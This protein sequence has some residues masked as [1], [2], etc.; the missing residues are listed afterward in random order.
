MVNFPILVFY[1]FDTAEVATP[2]PNRHIEG[3]SFAFRQRVALGC[4]EYTGVG[5]SGTLIFED[6]E[7]NT[8]LDQSHVES[9]VTA[10]IVRLGAS[11]SVVSNMR[12]FRS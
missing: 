1:E 11:G 6:V 2:I 12:L 3:G 9:K 7:F 4:Q 8:T 10:F 5:T